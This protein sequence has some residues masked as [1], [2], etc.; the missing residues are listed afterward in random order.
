MPA[1]RGSSLGL[2]DQVF[3]LGVLCVFKIHFG[4]WRGVWGLRALAVLAED[5][6]PIPSTH[7]AAESHL[8][9]TPEGLIL[10]SDTVVT[11]TYMQAK[12]LYI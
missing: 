11:Y 2:S 6:N 5:W 8:T 7:M 3:E 4:S 1:P 9:L 10:S 12:H